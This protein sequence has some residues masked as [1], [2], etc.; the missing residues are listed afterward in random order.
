[1]AVFVVG[2]LVVGQSCSKVAL[3]SSNLELSDTIEAKQID[4]FECER[5][6]LEE[7]ETATV[8]F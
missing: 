3:L 1:M 5:E 6:T 8:C 2:W 4:S 7:G